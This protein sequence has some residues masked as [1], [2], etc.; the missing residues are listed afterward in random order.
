MKRIITI[1][2]TIMIFSII[3][4]FAYAIGKII[5]YIYTSSKEKEDTLLLENRVIEERS[6][7]NKGIDF[8]SLHQINN[9]IIGWIEIPNTNINYPLLITTDNEFYLTHSY[10]KKLNKNGSIF[11][12]CNTTIFKNYKHQNIF[13]YGHNMKN[14]TMFNEMKN[15]VNQKYYD[16]NKIIYITFQNCKLELEV[17]SA[18]SNNDNSTFKQQF[19]S[20]EAYKNYLIEIVLRNRIKSNLNLEEISDSIF[21]F[22]TCSYEKE[23]SRYYIHARIKQCNYK[24]GNNYER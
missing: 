22:Y 13:I 7:E 2:K 4:I 14:I 21:T 24:E 8:D 11:L 15:Y 23:N 18:Y 3:V 19:M 16:E 5:A 20:D 1:L 17:F 10:D 6:D 12:D 9:E